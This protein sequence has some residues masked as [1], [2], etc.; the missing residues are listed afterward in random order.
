M[1]FFTVS[2]SLLNLTEDPLGQLN[3]HDHKLLTCIT[4]SSNPPVTIAWK[5]NE[6]NNKAITTYPPGTYEGHTAHSEVIITLTRDMNGVDVT[7][8]ALYKSGPGEDSGAEDEDTRTI[9]LDVACT[10]YKYKMLF[11]IINY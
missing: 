5:P 2:P 7:C 10:Q 1:Y 6:V 3:E 11:E 9:S 4:D 8:G